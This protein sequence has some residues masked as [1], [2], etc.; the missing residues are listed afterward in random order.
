MSY[1]NLDIS[2]V[3]PRNASLVVIVSVKSSDS[4][5]L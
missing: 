5:R 3:V 2:Q 1:M 4:E